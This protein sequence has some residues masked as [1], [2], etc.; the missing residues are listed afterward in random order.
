MFGNIGVMI[1]GHKYIRVLVQSDFLCW[2]V[3]MM[4]NDVDDD[5]D[6]MMIL[7]TMT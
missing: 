7:C 1:V 2:P 4:E 5:N 3:W 6:E